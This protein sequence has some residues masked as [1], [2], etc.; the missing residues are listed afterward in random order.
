MQ[1]SGRRLLLFSLA[2]FV[3]V[4]VFG[5]ALGPLQKALAGT[6]AAR[7]LASFHA[8]FDQL[9][10]LGSAALGA[11]LLF[12]DGSYRGPRWAPALLGWAYPLGALVFSGGH[13]IKAIGIALA[14]PLVPR[15]VVPVLASAGGVLLLAAVCGAGAIAASLLRPASIAAGAEALPGDRP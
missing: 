1:R 3:A 5:S 9:C 13:A 8:H 4:V 15:V 10:W 12:L 11:A 7:A 14:M 6:D 2:S